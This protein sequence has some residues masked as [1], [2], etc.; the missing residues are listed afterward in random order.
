MWQGW[1]KG[2]RTLQILAGPYP[3]LLHHTHSFLTTISLEAPGTKLLNTTYLFQYPRKPNTA[4][5]SPVY[6]LAQPRGSSLSNA[7]TVPLCLLELRVSHQPKSLMSSTSSMNISFT[8]ESLSLHLVSWGTG[9]PFPLPLSTDTCFLSLLLCGGRLD[10]FLA[11][12]CYF[13]VFFLLPDNKPQLCVWSHQIIKLHTTISLLLLSKAPW[14][15]LPNSLN[16][17]FLGLLP[18]N[19]ALSVIILVNSLFLPVLLL[20]YFS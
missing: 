1:A 15:T 9:S 12:H 19:P 17:S 4:R 5:C 18:L 10:A 6:L 11:P 7:T 2:P 13:Q 3:L 14:A 16:F 20:P 8:S